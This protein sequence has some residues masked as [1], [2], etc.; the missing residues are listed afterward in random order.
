MGHD[1]KSLATAP[2]EVEHPFQPPKGSNAKTAG[3]IADG[4]GSGP[5]NDIFSSSPK[6]IFEYSN[7]L[8]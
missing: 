5:E 8:Y 6:I 2:R 4:R 3:A 1:A 7:L